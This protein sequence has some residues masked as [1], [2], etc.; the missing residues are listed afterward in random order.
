MQ[1]VQLD[2]YLVHPAVAHHIG[3]AVVQAEGVDDLAVVVEDPRD[4][5]A[6]VLA[7][8]VIIDEGVFRPQL[9]RQQTDQLIIILTLDVQIDIVVPGDEILMTD[10][11]EQR[12]AAERVFDIVLPADPVQLDKDLQ[13]DVL[14]LAQHGQFL[15]GQH[16]HPHPSSHYYLLLYRIPPQIARASATKNSVVP[17]VENQWQIVYN[18]KKSG[19]EDR[20][21][22]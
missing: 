4:K 7:E 20:Y 13:L 19:N 5:V 6:E 21:A 2:E 14:D 10:R 22:V 16:I 12:A 3:L 11:A 18:Y 1:T 9:L 15:L 8:F 17:L